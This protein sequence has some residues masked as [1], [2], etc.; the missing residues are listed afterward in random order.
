MAQPPLS[1][2]IRHLE[3]EVGVR[4]LDRST[5]RVDLTDAGVAYLERAR[6][7]LAGVESAGD[8]ARRISSGVEGRLAVG[9]VGSATYSLLPAFARRL[10]EELPAVEVSFQG[11]ML[12]PRQVTALISGE[13][14]LALLRPPVDEPALRLRTLRTDRLMVAIPEGHPLA[15][16]RRLRIADLR[17]EDLVIHTPRGSVM[18]GTV[19]GLCRAEGFEPRIGHEVA[20]TSTLVTFVA[21]GLGVAVVPAPVA[22]L[23]VPGV[24][25]VPLHDRSARIG[26]AYAVR[27]DD[28]SPALARAEQVLVR[29]MSEGAAWQRHERATHL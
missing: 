8:E 17:G 6:E 16:R 19:A 22:E 27:A 25:Y 5:R 20:E 3:E 2:Q 13:I 10:R 1:Q 7:I 11:E 15:A 29:M 26:L 9:C 12:A 14:D 21:A 24:R 28:D 23:G 4:L 18:H